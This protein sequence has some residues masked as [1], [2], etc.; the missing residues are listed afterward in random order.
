MTSEIP[1]GHQSISDEDIDAV[2]GVLRSDWL[3]TGPAVRDFEAALISA[4][5]A[6]HAI[7]V[8]SGTA[9]LHVAYAAVGVGQ[10]SSRV[11]SHLLPQRPQRCSWEPM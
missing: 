11:R 7:A 8:T 2:A 6:R 5:Q 3:T 10:G 9:A 1:Y 4:A